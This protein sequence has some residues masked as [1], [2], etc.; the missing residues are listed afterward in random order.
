MLAAGILTAAFLLSFVATRRAL[1]AGVAATLMVGYLYGIVRANV[2]S[3]VAQFVYDAAVAGLFLAAL[4]LRL[5]GEQQARMRRLVPWVAA[6]IGWPTMLLLV[7]SQP[8]LIQLV[9]YRAVVLFVPFILIGA[10]LEPADL[11]SLAHWI[12]VLNIAVFALALAEVII[13]VPFFYP[14]N[15]LD[16]IIYNSTD[17]YFGGTG[18]FRIPGTF[19]NSA[20]FA[21]N[22][23]AGVPLLLGALSFE[24]RRSPIRYLL[25]AAAAASGI[26]VFL[27]ASR[28]S[29]VVLILMVLA[30]TFSARRGRFPR[31]SWVVVVVA[32]A[33]LVGSTPRLQRF[34]TLQESGIIE[35]RLHSSMN[36]SFLKLLSDYP[37][38]NGLGGGGTS[39]PYFLRPLLQNP[40]RI[41][42]EYAR[43]AAEQG[44]PGLIL[45]LAFIVWI[46]SR[47]RP[48][49]GD[50]WY[51]GRWL[52]R[53]F[54]AISFA[55]AP[56][57][58][59]LLNA[60]PQ[61]ATILM[62]TGWL[63]APRTDRAVGAQAATRRVRPVLSRSQA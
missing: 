41:E 12:A 56:V 60:V 29:A 47:P 1:W 51:T 14:R 3:P 32:I 18:H 62:F 48:Q 36:D 22:M 24:P 44:I 57:G 2:A 10:M 37:L 20:A 39:I 55:T 63:A 19:T 17:V 58:M 49:P 7:P 9:G 52:A 11:R 16:D 27:T 50:P 40:V 30:I 59:G 6:L 23:I 54:C 46:F 42:N 38:G 31:A 15:P 35:Q 5:R 43:I 25:L 53:L 61:T 13:G 45:W 26:A 4:T 34:L 21:T 28:S 8:I 33:L